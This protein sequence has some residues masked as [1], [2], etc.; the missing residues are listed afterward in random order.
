MVIA[1]SAIKI[2]ATTENRTISEVQPQVLGEIT[3]LTL[4]TSGVHFLAIVQLFQIISK[5]K[6]LD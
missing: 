4:P 2:F 6:N 1:S 5:S 3:F